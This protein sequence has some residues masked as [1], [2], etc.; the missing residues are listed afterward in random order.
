MDQGKQMRIT[1]E[2][3][4]LIRATFKGND[5]LLKLM[6][7]IFLPEIDPQAPLGQIV[8]LWMA[9][10]V[11][12][13]SNEQALVKLEARNTLILHVEQQL[14]GLKAMAESVDETPA[15]S[16]AKLKKDSSK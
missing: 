16:A 4:A 10:S 14:I 13:L 5:A 8:D 12:D 11:K 3:M 6:R 1:P 9:L 15:Q 7:K 2:E